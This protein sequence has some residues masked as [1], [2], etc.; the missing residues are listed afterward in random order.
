MYHLCGALGEEIST[1]S[2][3]PMQSN[4]VPPQKS[5]C[6]HCRPVMHF[7]YRKKG[8]NKETEEIEEPDETEGTC[9]AT[10][11]L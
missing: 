6:N 1:A 7:E 8:E 3:W 11:Q 9:V 5:L 2:A 4:A 10:C